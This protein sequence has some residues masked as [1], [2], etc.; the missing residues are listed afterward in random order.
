MNLNGG[1]ASVEELENLDGVETALLLIDSGVGT[2]TPYGVVYDNCMRLEQ[3]Y[4]G[5]QFPEYL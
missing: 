3:L 2:V 1:S 5:R 4:N